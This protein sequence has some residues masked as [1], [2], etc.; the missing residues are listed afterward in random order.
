MVWGISGVSPFGFWFSGNDVRAQNSY[1]GCSGVA[2]SHP[3][4]CL[5]HASA[6]SVGVDEPHSHSTTHWLLGAACFVVP[7][8]RSLFCLF[9]IL[10][11]VLTKPLHLHR[12]P[13]GRLCAIPFQGSIIQLVLP[14]GRIAVTDP[15]LDWTVRP[16]QLPKHRRAVPRYP[17]T[18]IGGV[19]CKILVWCLGF[20]SA[21]TVW[22]SPPAC[23]YILPLLAH[24]A[25]AMARPGHS[26]HPV[27]PRPHELPPEQ[28]TTAIGTCDVHVSQEDDR[29]YHPLASHIYQG[30]LPWHD[31]PT[32][33]A[34][35]RWLGVYCYSPHYCTQSFA[36]RVTEADGLQEVLDKI[37]QLAPGHQTAF[38]DTARPL[39]PQRI[40][41]FLSVIQFPSVIRALQD[42]YAAVVADLT[43]VGGKYFPVILPKRMSYDVLH[44]YLRP[45]T[46]ALHDEVCIY[47]GSRSRPWPPQ[48]EVVIDD[49]E[50]I[51]TLAA[52]TP[53][54]SNSRAT[55]LFVA[56][57][58]WGPMHHFFRDEKHEAV[59][60][61]Y[62]GHRY[63]FSSR[64]HVGLTLLDF[65]CDRFRLDKNRI[66]TCAFPIEDLDVQGD[67][68]SVLVAQDLPPSATADRQLRHDCFTLLDLRPFGL[69][70]QFLHTHVPTH[71]VPSI[72]AD[73]GIALPRHL[74]IGVL[75]GRLRDEVVTAEPNT[76]LVFHPVRASSDS[77]S[78]SSDEPDGDPEPA[79]QVAYLQP[80]AGPPPAVPVHD[81]S[82]ESWPPPW[83][84]HGDTAA[85]FYDVTLPS[86]HSW[87]EGANSRANSRA[88][89]TQGTAWSP[90]DGHPAPQVMPAPEDG[91]SEGAAAPAPHV[92]DVAESEPRVPLFALV[93]VPDILPELHTVHLHVPCSIS[94]ALTG[95]LSGRSGDSAMYF[96]AVIP[97]VPQPDP[98][99]MIFVAKPG[100][101]CSKPVVLFDCRRIDQT[102]FAQAVFPELN[103]ESIL[104]AAG[105]RPR[106]QF[107]V[108]VHGLLQPLHQGQ[109]ISLTDGMLITLVPLGCG[110]PAT[111][112]LASRLLC[113]EGWGDEDALPGPPMFPGRHHW[114]LTDGPSIRFTIADDRRPHFRDDMLAALGSE[115]HR[116]TV[117]PSVPRISTGFFQ[118]FRVNGVL[119]AT[120]Q[121][122][123][124]PVPP[125]GVQSLTLVSSLTVGTS[126]GLSCG[127]LC[128][129]TKFLSRPSSITFWT[130]ALQDTS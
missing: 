34:G 84:T 37:Q 63:S 97:V 119:V 29:Q 81:D 27:I 56:D 11:A 52:G 15:V 28:L 68:C 22:Y 128:K 110:A 38:C 83:E 13:L 3:P 45:M 89:A 103:R 24:T 124:L 43:R 96:P 16:K 126:C 107:A 105:R 18:S 31:A 125:A 64:H 117:K 55:D 32:N 122:C 12:T 90:I 108:Y 20:S 7:L 53:P 47:I 99:F 100:W 78:S 1:I 42:G 41:G 80:P 5:F 76:T 33:T 6:C 85:E 51:T 4:H 116:L 111:A 74:R 109:T 72:A 93:Y 10:L 95:L 44:E 57:V 59:C 118:G 75:G 121:V 112:D 26:D 102:M 127:R 91:G 70:P 39:R 79:A 21:P 104:L 60:I 40:E 14:L 88:T 130:S 86:E 19:F 36:I 113:T 8:F 71:H 23:V 73:V 106:E 87:N 25:S 77:S 2:A 98:A 123:R 62:R 67:L 54:P 48:A 120:E 101:F 92:D 69:K 50:V 46:S 49:G 94:Q 65:V 66:L 35:D 61:L 115:P 114:L 30:S 58:P 17:R 129:V 82:V 9:P